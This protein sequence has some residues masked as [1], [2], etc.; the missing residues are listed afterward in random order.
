[1]E[2]TIKSGTTVWV[3]RSFYSNRPIERLDMVLYEAGENGDPHRGTGTKIVK[4]VIG[5]GGETVEIV[6][7]KVL[8]NGFEL[9]QTFD[10]IPDEDNF[11]R[12]TV[13][14]GEYFLLGDNRGN[15]YDSRH[16]NPPTIKASSIKGKV[17]EIKNN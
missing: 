12:V 7:G 8:I 2:P 10:S 11:G 9:K 3:D 4:R 5:L 16:W 17:T 15:S 1:M 6:N 13:P 14:A